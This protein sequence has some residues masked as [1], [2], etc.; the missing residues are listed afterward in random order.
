MQL[1]EKGSDKMEL[2]KEQKKKLKKWLDE[3]DAAVSSMDLE[4]FKKWAKNNYWKEMPSD[5]VLEITMRK[6][7]VHIT[8]IDVETR[9][10]AFRWLIE[11]GHDISLEF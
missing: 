3:R 9:V 6:M 4:K 10:Y 11:R 8:S 5:E 7:A 2:S 1:K